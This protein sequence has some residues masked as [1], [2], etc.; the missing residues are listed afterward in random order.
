MRHCSKD[1]R[2]PIS[3]SLK[4]IGSS[5]LFFISAKKEKSKGES[6]S[7]VTFI[8]SSSG[9]GPG[10]GVTTGNT[11]GISVAVG[12]TVGGGVSVRVGA[13]VL[14]AEGS[15][16]PVAAIGPAVQPA[17]III[18]AEIIPRN[19]FRLFPIHA[20]PDRPQLARSLSPRKVNLI[21]NSP[22]SRISL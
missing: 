19:T 4:I 11:V 7:I 21:P 16:G 3:R 2:T 9:A 1:N 6:F 8:N 12:V 20:L 22:A 10:L 5:E 18:P 14:V 17:M 13:G 15:A